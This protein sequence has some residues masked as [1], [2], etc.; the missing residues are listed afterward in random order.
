MFD[1]L[2]AMTHRGAVA[3]DGKTGDG[4]GV[5]MAMPQAF[6]RAIAKEEGI[7]LGENFA[8]GMVF[9]SRDEAVARRS[10]HLL[11]RHLADELSHARKLLEILSPKSSFERGFSLTRDADGKVARVFSLVENVTRQKQL[12]A[13]VLPVPGH[14]I[15]RRLSG[16]ELAHDPVALRADLLVGV[17]PTR[18]QERRDLDPDVSAVVADE[19]VRPQLPQVEVQV[20][21]QIHIAEQYDPHADLVLYPGDCLDLLAQIPDRQV[22]LVVTSPPYNLGIDY[23]SYAD[24]GERG[25]FISW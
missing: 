9:L 13:R 21:I 19:P 2:M 15:E 1:R 20:A 5:L 12:Q 25:K 14:G 23:T 18:N 16:A 11:R 7:W 22:Q 17:V 8:V 4:C 6:F 3:V 10:R 24:D